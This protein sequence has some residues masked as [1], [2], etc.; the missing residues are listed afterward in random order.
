[1]DECE[2]D[3]SFRDI[4][5]RP[6]TDLGEVRQSV[7]LAI[8]SLNIATAEFSAK[9][10]LLHSS[11]SELVRESV[12]E[13]I[14]DQRELSESNFRALASE[15]K[16]KQDF[17]TERIECHDNEI[18]ILQV[19]LAGRPT[20]SELNEANIAIEAIDKRVKRIEKAPG[21]KALRAMAAIGG[22]ITTGVVVS[23]GPKLLEWVKALLHRG[24]K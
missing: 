8:S 5:D 4:A 14:A 2:G 15:L 20:R 19:D 1:M 12:K 18:Q 3:G 24:V 6:M 16:A 17:H 22:V 21:D 11:L 10:N 7:Q 23:E 9:V 13:A